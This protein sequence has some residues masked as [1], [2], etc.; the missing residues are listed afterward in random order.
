MKTN[1][2]SI[3]KWRRFQ[4]KKLRIL[5]AWIGGMILFYYSGISETTFWA[6]FPLVILGELTRIWA[7]GHVERKG[8]KLATDGPFA[9]ARNPL[10]IGNFLLGLGFV[11]VCGNV[12]FIA[13]FLIGFGIVYWGTI[14]KEEKDL[15]ELFGKTYQEYCRQVPRI[16]PRFSPYPGREKFSFQW[17]LILKHREHVTAMAVVLGLSGLYLWERV[18][19]KHGSVSGKET[20]AAGIALAMILGLITEALLRQAAKKKVP[21]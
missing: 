14:R 16:F 7:A 13:I 1:L 3:A 4:F 8:Q 11:T 19:L 21:S 2:E 9:Y 10:Y 12:L 20:F 18:G 6:G 15:S 5:L 17:P